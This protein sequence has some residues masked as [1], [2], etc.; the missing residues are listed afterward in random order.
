MTTG[1]PE[2]DAYNRALKETDSIRAQAKR[3]AAM[4]A[5]G[6]KMLAQD[7]DTW[8]FREPE[9]QWERAMTISPRLMIL[10]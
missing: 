7:P 10:P 9:A 3:L 1:M 4:V 8:R 2:L 5:E 6:A